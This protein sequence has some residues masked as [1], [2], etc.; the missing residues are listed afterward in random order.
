MLVGV[1]SNPNTQLSNS[2]AQLLLNLTRGKW[3]AK[4]V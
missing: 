1:V 3:Y 2:D 4:L